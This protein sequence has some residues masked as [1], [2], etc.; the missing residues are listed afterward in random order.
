MEPKFPWLPSCFVDSTCLQEI[1]AT[2][3]GP[4]S[5][6][7]TNLGWLDRQAHGLSLDLFT[8]S[9]G[10]GRVF[11]HSLQLE[12]KHPFRRVDVLSLLKTQSARVRSSASARTL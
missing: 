10:G 11:G 4:S 7:L 8:K 1:S 5:I 2:S 6:N 12:L 9:S 3:A